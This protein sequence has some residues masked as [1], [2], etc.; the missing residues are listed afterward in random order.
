METSLRF[1][2]AEDLSPAS[3]VV[4]GLSGFFET[5]TSVVPS[6]YGAYARIYHPA[7]LVE[8][9]SRTPKTWREI[10]AENGRTA[11]REMQWYGIAG[12]Y[13]SLD[14]DGYP[15]RDAQVDPTK[16]WLEL[17]A[18]GTLPAEIADPLL[19]ILFGHTK[20]REGWFGVWEGFNLT[21]SQTKPTSSFGPLER[22]YL[23]FGAPL[24][25]ITAS[26]SL[27][28]LHQSA[29]L[30]WP[31]DR[32]WCVA[33]EVDFM[34]TYIGGTEEAIRA[35][36]ES[37]HLESDRVEPSDRVSADPLNAPVG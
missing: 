28:P 9:D 2:A 4:A 8:G 20:S 1:S 30:W 16:R 25:A 36:V 24:R 37:P 10:A 19:R 22:R 34:T 3:W 29:N 21:S 18:M 7:W 12:G 14:D 27:P 32:A 35:I 33:T 13:P 6:G 17:P 26:F 15:L 5:V 11:H 31:E 23:L